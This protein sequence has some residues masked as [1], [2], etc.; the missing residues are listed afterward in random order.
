MRARQLIV[1]L[2]L[3]CVAP[4]SW[5]QQGKAQR[6]YVPI[7]FTGD[8]ESMLRHRL[9][10]ATDWE[11]FLKKVP[12][13]LKRLPQLEKLKDDERF[14]DILRMLKDQKLDNINWPKNLQDFEQ[15]IKKQI[16]QQAVPPVLPKDGP[17]PPE[18]AVAPMQPPMQQL[19]NSQP[20]RQDD[21]Q[22]RF[23]RWVKER[24]KDMDGSNIGDMLRDSPAWQKT[25]EDIGRSLDNIR[26]NGDGWNLRGVLDKWPLADNLKLPDL[27]K[28]LKPPDW[29]MPELPRVQIAMPG[30]QID[31]PLGGM[32]VPALPGTRALAG[33]WQVVLWILAALAAAFILWQAWKSLERRGQRLKTSWHPGPWPVLPANVVSRAEFVACFDHL[34]LLLL[35]RAATTWNHR[36]VAERIGVE[37]PGAAPLGVEETRRR[38]IAADLATLYEWARYSPGEEPLPEAN[39]AEARSALEYFARLQ[40]TLAAK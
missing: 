34:S 37:R 18:K 22:D 24:I 26:G 38:Q 12:P 11:E 16:D 2:I 32:R 15:V 31:N 17:D 28:W 8:L 3:S 20:P 6:R 27:D 25:I 9:I 36:A 13:A 1:F 7:P 10:E 4:S 29:N 21:M 14:R 33:G 40:P 23:D 30:L 5:A 35:G 39:L 19:P